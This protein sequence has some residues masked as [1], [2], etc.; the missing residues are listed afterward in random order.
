MR[1]TPAERA[2]KVA[3]L[4]ARLEAPTWRRQ[5]KA[6]ADPEKGPGWPVVKRPDGGAEKDGDGSPIEPGP[7]W[8]PW[9]RSARNQLHTGVQ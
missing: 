7:S 8:G 6:L 4:A 1:L 2:R 9:R 5:V 3:D